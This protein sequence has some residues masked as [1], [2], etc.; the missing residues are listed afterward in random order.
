MKPFSNLR[1]RTGQ[2]MHSNRRPVSFRPAAIVQ[3]TDGS[4]LV[5]CVVMDGRIKPNF[6]VEKESGQ[7]VS[8][9]ISMQVGNC[10][11]DLV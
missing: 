10:N 2:W 1:L 3:C 4:T 8:S 9:S 6:A 7:S 11:V 5:T